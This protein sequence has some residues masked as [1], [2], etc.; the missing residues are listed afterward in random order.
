MG[1]AADRLADCALPGRPPLQQGGDTHRRDQRIHPPA[2]DLVGQGQRGCA[3]QAGRDVRPGLAR[4]MVL[5]LYAQ[6]DA[7]CGK[8][9]VPLQPGG[10]LLGQC[11]ADAVEGQV[12]T[13]RDVAGQGDDRG[14]QQADHEGLL[15]GRGLRFRTPGPVRRT[16]SP[17]T[18]PVP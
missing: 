1:V 14:E 9:H 5:H 10:V 13:G 8:I 18:A 2:K 4:E 11:G 6:V 7:Q 17:R 15:H 16:G 12:R 3:E